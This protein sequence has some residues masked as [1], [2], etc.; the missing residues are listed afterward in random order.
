VTGENSGAREVA[1]VIGVPGE[2][3]SLDQFAAV[4][5]TNGISDK[6]VTITAISGPR[7]PSATKQ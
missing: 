2:A 7:A 3:I 4:S 1:N 5:G 6:H